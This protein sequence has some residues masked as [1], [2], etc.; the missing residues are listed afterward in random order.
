M[1]HHFY[2]LCALFF[3][4]LFLFATLCCFV[5]SEKFEGDLLNYI[6][7]IDTHCPFDALLFNSRDILG[8]FPPHS[9][10]CPH[11]VHNTIYYFQIL[12]L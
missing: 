7:S 12:L 10:F 2:I 3:P 9:I 8:I 5:I 11:V 1:Q 6:L 4:F